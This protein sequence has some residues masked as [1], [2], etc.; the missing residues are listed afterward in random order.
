MQVGE[1]QKGDYVHLYIVGYG[2]YR[3]ICVVPGKH[4]LSRYKGGVW[5]LLYPDPNANQLLELCSLS[6]ITD[7]VDHIKMVVQHFGDN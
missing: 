5:K 4:Y 3:C 7:Y 6:D 1:E 2:G